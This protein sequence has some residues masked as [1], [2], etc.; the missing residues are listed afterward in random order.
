MMRFITHFSPKARAFRK[1]YKMFRRI[2]PEFYEDLSDARRDGETIYLFIKERLAKAIERKSDLAPLYARWIKRMDQEEGLMSHFMLGS[3]P[4]SDILYLSTIERTDSFNDKLNFLARLI[5]SQ[6][7]MRKTA[8][9]IFLIPA[10]SLIVLVIYFLVQALYVTPIF[11]EVAPPSTWGT[12]GQIMYALSYAVKNF[13]IFIAAGAYGLFHWFNWSLTNWTGS[14]RARID[15]WC[16]PYKLARD[17]NGA[18]FLMSIA[19]LMQGDQMT[20]VKALEMVRRNAS[21]WL[22]W[23]V[24]HILRRIDSTSGNY[25]VAFDT[26]VLPRDITDRLASFSRRSGSVAKALEKV[27]IDGMGKIQDAISETIDRMNIVLI[28]VIGLIIGCT[29]LGTL[30]TS[31][32]VTQG[33]KEQVRTQRAVR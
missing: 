29:A 3:V 4:D 27:G 16:L 11:E 7:K 21:P 25:G 10:L 28:L 13:G 23:H 22:R 19:T 6:E 17:Y 14:T 20:L 31:Q 2:R 26:G 32:G 1:A 33:V 18:M 30:L 5:R 9:K 15:Q 24:S 12:A 8:V